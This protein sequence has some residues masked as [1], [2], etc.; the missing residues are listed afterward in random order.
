MK[1]GLNDSNIGYE[2]NSSLNNDI[3]QKII[4]KRD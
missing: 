2:A 1:E 4:G 3:V